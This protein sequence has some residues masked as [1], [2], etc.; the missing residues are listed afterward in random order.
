MIPLL[1]MMAYDRWAN[2]RLIKAAQQLDSARLARDLN[3]SF[4]SVHQTLLHIVWAEELW[5]ERW[6]GHSFMPSLDP[7]AFSTV[8]SLHHHFEEVHA[9]QRH[10]LEVLEAGA[11]DQRIGY[12]NFRGQRWEY[13]LAQMVQHL[14]THSAYHRGQLATM[15]R[16]LGVVPP[17]TDYLVYV[18]EQ[19]SA[20]A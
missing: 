17:T 19:T 9:R 14:V 4:S 18:D 5:L 15:L 6:H 7:T 12:V 13:S 20:G 1:E 11:D 2:N 16:Q 8:Q 10:F 3:S